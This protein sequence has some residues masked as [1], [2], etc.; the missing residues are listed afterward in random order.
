VDAQPSLT[1]K[2]PGERLKVLY[3]P[4]HNRDGRWGGKRSKQLDDA[5]DG[6]VSAGV[7]DAVVPSAPVAPHALL[8]LRRSV[9]VTIDEIITGGHHQVSLE[10]LCCGNAVITGADF[11]SRAMLCTS[12]R[13]PEM[14]PFVRAEPATIGEILVDLARDPARLNALQ[15]ASADFFRRW[16]IPERLGTIYLDIYKEV[17]NASG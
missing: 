13:I 15:T 6:L 8:E 10:G 5:I 12:A 16:L 3:S 9:H 11:F 2:H 1:T 14:P 4:S 17:L 7:I